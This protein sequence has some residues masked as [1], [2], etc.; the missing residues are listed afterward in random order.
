MIMHIDPSDLRWS[1]AMLSLAHHLVYYLSI[2]FNIS[3]LIISLSFF[4]LLSL[5]LFFSLSLYLFFFCISVTYT[6]LY[7][8][9]LLLDSASR[10]STLVIIPCICTPLHRLLSIL[11]PSLAVGWWWWFVIISCC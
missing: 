9:N 3:I 10:V 4:F 5:S 7:L 8:I 1:V 6:L 11:T 2:L